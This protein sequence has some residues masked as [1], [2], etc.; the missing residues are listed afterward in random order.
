MFDIDQRI[1]WI[2]QVFKNDSG[3]KVKA[4]EGLTVDFCK[5][6]NIPFIIRGLRSSVDFEFEKNIAEMN[7]KI[8]K[9]IETVFLLTSP[10]LSC[11]TSTIIRELIKEK[12]DI[13]R[14]VPE[15]VKFN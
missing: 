13:S 6:N 15:A 14:F 3:V 12:A 1:H 11:I 5:K 7:K 9:D 4:Y 2:E 8:N 10:D